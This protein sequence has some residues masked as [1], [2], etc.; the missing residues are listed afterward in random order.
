MNKDHLFRVSLKAV[1]RND[2]GQ[3]LVV[4]ERGQKVWGLPGGGMDYGETY[5][6]A[7]Q[8][9]LY[10]EV[11]YRG[12]FAMKIIGVNDPAILKNRDTQIWQ[13]RLVFEVTC[14]NDDFSAGSDGE[15]IAFISAED[16]ESNRAAFDSLVYTYCIR[17]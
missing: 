10:E 5:E 7:L 6:Q 9:E 17:P 12:A 15:E 3:L 13:T 11:G 4:R 2:R 14:E 16:V 1:I 8:R